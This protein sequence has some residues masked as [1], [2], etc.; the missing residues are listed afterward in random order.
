MFRGEKYIVNSWMR[1][2]L[3]RI[4]LEIRI[5]IINSFLTNLLE[6]LRELNHKYRNA[7]YP[8]NETTYLLLLSKVSNASNYFGK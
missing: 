1:G 8:I 4:Y 2:I 5:D 3:N 6:F 7:S